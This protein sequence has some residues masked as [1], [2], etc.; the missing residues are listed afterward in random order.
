M[1]RG[2]LTIA[3]LA[4]FLNNTCE[5]EKDKKVFLR[6]SERHTD[7]RVASP[8][9]GVDRQT[10]GWTDMCENI[11]FPHPSDAVSENDSIRQKHTDQ[12]EHVPYLSNEWQ[13]DESPMKFLW[14]V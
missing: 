6:Q 10:D 14:S 2:H 13:L 4:N 7:R 5:N 3:V 12:R 1:T 11:T 8:G 9:G